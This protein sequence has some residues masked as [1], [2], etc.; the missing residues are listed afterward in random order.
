MDKKGKWYGTT[1]LTFLCIFWIFPV[2]CV[3]WN[4]FKDKTSIN[5]KPFEL[6]AGRTFVG[7]ENYAQA[8]DKYGLLKS[9]GWTVFITVFSVAAILICCSAA[10]AT[11]STK[12]ITAF[13]CP[14]P[15]NPERP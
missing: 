11:T 2:L 9:V 1:F 15:S 6:P 7:W 10:M 3:L 14:T 5:L 13:A 12:K 4:S 8:I